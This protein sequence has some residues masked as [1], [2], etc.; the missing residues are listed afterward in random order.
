MFEDKIPAPTVARNNMA[1]KMQKNYIDMKTK[2]SVQNK[3]VYNNP[4][5]SSLKIW[6]NI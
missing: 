6:F 1:S 5:S 4:P 2:D 3:P